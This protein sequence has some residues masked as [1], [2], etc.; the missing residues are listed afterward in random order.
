MTPSPDT[1]TRLLE[2][3]RELFVT[4]GFAEASTRAIASCR[5]SS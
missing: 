5:S 1:R 4:Y 3:A 2:A